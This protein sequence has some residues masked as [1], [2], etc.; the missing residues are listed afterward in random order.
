MNKEIAKKWV[1][2]LRSDKYNQGKEAL[3]KIDPDDGTKYHCCLGVLT[4]MYQKY[5]KK[6]KKKSL[7]TMLISSDPNDCSRVSYLSAYSGPSGESGVLPHE[8]MLWAEMSSNDGKIRYSDS[9]LDEMTLAELN[10]CSK[11]F[12]QIAYIIER[13]VNNL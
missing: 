6:Q 13:N 11:S 1:K 7:K 5:R 9:T 8:V 12:K 10:D 2:A 3:C 4:D